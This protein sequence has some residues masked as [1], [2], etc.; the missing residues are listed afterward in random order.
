VTYGLSGELLSLN[1]ET[2][3]Y[4][5]RLQLTRIT[6]NG[7]ANMEYRYSPTQNNGQITQQKDWNPGGEEVTYTYDS[8]QRLI[9]AVTTD[10][11]WGQA[12]TYDGFGNRTSASVTQGMAP[13]GNWSYYANTNWMVGSG[14]DANGNT[15]ST[16]T[17]TGL[18]YDVENRLVSVPAPSQNVYPTEVYAYA[19]DNKRI[20]KRKP[21]GSEELYF[22][23]ISGQKLATYATAVAANGDFFISTLDTNLYFGSRTIVS[24]GVTVALDRL[25]S[26][27]SGGSHYFPYGEEQQLTA[28]DR[29][30]FA[31]YYRDG[32][33]GLDYAQNRYYASTPGRFLS[34]D[35]FQAASAGPSDP[36]SWNQYSYTRGDPVNRYDPSGMDDCPAGYA[37]FS[38]TVTESNYSGGFAGDPQHFNR[39][40][41]YNDEHGDG[42]GGAQSGGGTPANKGGW[43]TNP[44]GAA[45][46]GW[47]YLSSIWKDCLDYFSKD[48][49]FSTSNFQNLLSNGTNNSGSG[50][51]GIGWWDTRGASIAN[52]TVGSIANNGNPSTLTQYLGSQGFGV[53]AA[54]L[55]PSK[56][57][58]LS[59][60][61]FTNL[62]QTQQ[63]AATIHEALHLQFGLGDVDLQGL[64]MN[65]G[66]RPNSSGSGAI[67]D[68][69]ATD[70]GKKP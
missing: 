35:P 47:Q 45:K 11:S 38:T 15:T 53:T 59:Q 40:A 25:G 61:F 8:L 12:F 68:W 31:T 37:C 18:A 44:A 13:H 42:G 23:G 46:T 17:M 57:V 60:D 21:D 55:I 7:G 6:T 65:W 52:R 22:Y 48:A 51:G 36:Q 30:K 26:N 66:F 50:S 67:T 4:N 63:I 19:A 1:N 70:C 43:N 69:I 16:Q 2:R 20:W 10:S 39:N 32:T 3:T 28:Q 24:R 49:R 29:D 56:N 58:A 41:E 33:T 27:Q 64:L 34:P 9:G 62:T 5:S 14:Y 54:V